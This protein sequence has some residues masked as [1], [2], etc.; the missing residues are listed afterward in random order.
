MKRVANQTRSPHNQVRQRGFYF[1]RLLAFFA[2]LL[3]TACNP[4]FQEPAQQAPYFRPP[5]AVHAP[6][7]AEPTTPISA[8]GEQAVSG[9]QAAQPSGADC[10]DNLVFVQ[11]LTIP[12]GT[13]VAPESTLDKRWEVENTGNCNWDAKYRVRLIAGPELGAQKEQALYPARVGSRATIRILFK[14]PAEN[15]SY[16]SAWQSFN[17][18]GDPFGEPFFIDIKVGSNP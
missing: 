7:L 11:D 9:Q 13:I 4:A 17:A 2:A 15:G 5:T 10:R 8:G 14:A 1:P 6:V 18:Q 12:D 16:R 3:M